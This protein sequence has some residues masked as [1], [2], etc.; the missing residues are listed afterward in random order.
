M[1][2]LFALKVIFVGVPLML[3]IMILFQLIETY[4]K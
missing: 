4:K 2:D 3:S 1:T